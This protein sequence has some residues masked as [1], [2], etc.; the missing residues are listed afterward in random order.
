[1]EDY[2]IL[3]LKNANNVV[4]EHHKTHINKYVVHQLL[5]IVYKL[6]EVMMKMILS[7]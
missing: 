7:A 3:P 2:M 6:Y 1:M 5:Q 4:L